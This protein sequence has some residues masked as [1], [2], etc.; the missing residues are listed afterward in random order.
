M[1]NLSSFAQDIQNNP[2]DYMTE[3]AK[4]RGDMDVKY[5]QY[6]SAAAHGRR[7]RKVEKL[8]QQVLDNITEC[9]YKTTGLPKYKGD[10]SLRQASID[11]IQFCYR[12]FNEDYKKIVDMEELA[13]QS[14]DEMQAYILLH[15]MVSQKLHEASANLQKATADFAT[16]Y[17]INLIED[18]SP[19]SAKMEVAS[20]LNHYSNNVYLIFFKC[21]WEDNQMV[22]AMN[23]KKLNDMEQSRN[24]LARYANEGFKTLDTM[25]VFEGD[26]SLANACRETLTFYKNLAEKDMAQLTDF[27]LKQDDFEKTKKAFDAKSGNATKQDVND[28]NKAVKELNNAV[29]AFNQTNNKVN[30][31]RKQV[32][33][34]W[35]NAEKKFADAHM[36]YYR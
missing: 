22:T 6:V 24:A 23:N 28:Y 32:L 15:E 12:V 4:A 3:I 30:N 11:Y 35:D 1:M 27:F 34:D 14:F 8:R 25:K 5:M 2:G 7:A 26:P 20:K 10:N 16:K 18:Q 19:L 21:N 33:N 36:P 31:N 17:N 9:R 13:E 29:N